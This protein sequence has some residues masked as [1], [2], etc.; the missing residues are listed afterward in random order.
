[1]LQYS[2]FGASEWAFQE[3]VRQ[4]FSWL[5]AFAVEELEGRWFL[6]VKEGAV[7]EHK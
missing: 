5:G 7:H 1:M 2:L 3:S 4:A 6:T